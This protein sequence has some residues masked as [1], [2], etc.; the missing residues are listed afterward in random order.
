M[1]NGKFGNA[2]VGAA[3]FGVALLV[4]ACAPQ[5]AGESG[6]TAAA[7][8]STAAVSSTAL[9][10]ATLAATI[11][12]TP[13]ITVYKSPTCGCCAIW[14]DHMREAGFELDVL[15]MDDAALV[16]VKLDAG[17]PLRMQTCHTALVGDYVF[18]GHI[19]A[20]VIA[21]FLAEKPAASGLAVPG[22]PIGSPG[23]EFGDRVDPYD[24]LAFDAAGNT[25]VYESR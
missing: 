19:P 6:R 23:M 12:E 1:L 13:T 8:S 9:V 18:E 17:V 2:G 24:V 10:D 21:R 22:M 15:D 20:E 11:A 3:F 14:V 7:A 4:T 16:R 5:A 25:S